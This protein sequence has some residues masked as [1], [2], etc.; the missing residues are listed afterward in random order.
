VGLLLLTE[1]KFDVWAPNA[2]SRGPL[3]DTVELFEKTT[4]T[5]TSE[6]LRIDAGQPVTA[7]HGGKAPTD[8]LIVAGLS[9]RYPSPSIFSPG[10][11]VTNQSLPLQFDSSSPSDVLPRD[12]LHFIPTGF[13]SRG[14]YSVVI[15]PGDIDLSDTQIP[16]NRIFDGRE[17]TIRHLGLFSSESDGA[18]AVTAGSF[19]NSFIDASITARSPLTGNRFVTLSGGVVLDKGTT[20][21]IGETQATKQAFQQFGNEFT[22]SVLS[23]LAKDGNPAFLEIQ[24]RALGVLYGSSI[25]ETSGRVALLSILDSR[26]I[27]PGSTSAEGRQ[28]GDVPPLLELYAL[29]N[30]LQ[31]TGTAPRVDVT[32]AVVVRSSN[33][34]GLDGALLEASSPIL[35]MAYGNMT[36]KSHFADFSGTNGKQVFQA[37]VPNDA[38][39]R[40]NHSNLTVNGNLFQFNNASASV[41]GRLFSLDNGSS[42]TINGVVLSLLGRSTFNLTADS[43]GSF[44]KTGTNTLTVNNNLCAGG[45]CR[46]INGIKVAG[47]GTVNLPSDFSPFSSAD[48]SAR[49]ADGTER[50]K[51]G[52]NSAFLSVA[53]NSTLNV[54]V[55]R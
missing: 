50:L 49:N 12:V 35:A 23:V 11:Q 17:G 13:S 38:L 44:G 46:T 6:L 52:Q 20:V 8:P 43:F 53:P 40:L 18:L 9:P 21:T 24:N 7:P 16:S 47:G 10:K 34:S 45:G 14:K 41:T 55:K 2:P 25:T 42:L 30:N 19:A 5:A 36:A 51:L 1:R 33:I 28:P 48:G 15:I 26:V 54:K 3:T 29:D 22:G 32:S 37:L 27:G 31:P 39:V 4:L